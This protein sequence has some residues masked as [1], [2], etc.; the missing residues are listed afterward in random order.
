M[1]DCYLQA[2]INALEAKDLGGAVCFK[3]IIPPTV[4]GRKTAFF[5]DFSVVESETQL[6]L[7]SPN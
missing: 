7:K 6:K 5:S 4:F 1:N 3:I 2:S